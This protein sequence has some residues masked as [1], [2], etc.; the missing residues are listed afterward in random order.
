MT[1][2]FTAYNADGAIQF[3][4]SYPNYVLIKSGTSFTP[5]SAYFPFQGVITVTNANN[6][7][8]AFRGNNYGYFRVGKSG[9][10]WTFYIFV[11]SGGY[12]FQGYY[13]FDDVTTTNIN[14]GMTIYDET[15][16][17]TYSSESYPLRLRNFVTTADLP[18]TSPQLNTPPTTIT[19]LDTSKT[20]AVIM[21][22][23]RRFVYTT[24][25]QP[26]ISYA[27]GDF[28]NTTVAGQITITFSL[29]VSGQGTAPY[30]FSRAGGTV[31][32]VDVTNY[33]TIYS[34]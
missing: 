19:G 32:A 20:Y 24:Q 31:L 13:I 17:L 33:P 7:I 6:P 18:P 30:I 28:L 12:N 16:A 15:G 4:A 14:V 9:S 29:Y 10:T 23:P 1:A 2:G 27:W 25:Q 21:C 11:N 34:I 22:S 3:D 26:F 5:T 8:I